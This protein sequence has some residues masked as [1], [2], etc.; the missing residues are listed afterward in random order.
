MRSGLNCKILTVGQ[1]RSLSVSPD[2][3]F[4]YL[5]H[6]IALLQTLSREMHFGGIFLRGIAHMKETAIFCL[7]D[8]WTTC[9]M[10]AQASFFIFHFQNLGFSRFF[11][12]P[13]KAPDSNVESKMCML[14]SSYKA[15]KIHFLIVLTT[16]E[17]NIIILTLQIR[18]FQKSEVKW[19]AQS[20]MDENGRQAFPNPKTVLSIGCGT[21]AYHCQGW[22]PGETEQSLQNGQR[23]PWVLF[24][25]SHWL[26][27]VKPIRIRVS[28][29]S[30]SSASL[31]PVNGHFPLW[32]T[33]IW[34]KSPDPRYFRIQWSAG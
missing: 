33:H 20:C 1:T 24:P 34:V 15:W 16:T 32:D 21:S 12:W 4:C 31:Y 10:K 2:F 27:L 13:M 28:L 23:F 8:V 30:S 9:A 26:E 25:G 29:G 6:T 11:A 19:L 5:L 3:T 14:L 17:D 7:K 22:H 18:T